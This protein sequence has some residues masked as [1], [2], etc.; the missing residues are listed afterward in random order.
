MSLSCRRSSTGVHVA[1]PPPGRHERRLLGGPAAVPVHRRRPRRR[2]HHLHVHPD[3]E[4]RAGAG[5]RRLPRHLGSRRPPASGHQVHLRRV[6]AGRPASALFWGRGCRRG[7]GPDR[8]RRRRRWRSVWWPR[9][10]RRR[11][12]LPGLENVPINTH[13]IQGWKGTPFFESRAL[14]GW[15]WKVMPLARAFLGWFRKAVP[16]A[17]ALFAL[18]WACPRALGRA[19]FPKIFKNAV[20]PVQLSFEIL[21]LR[22]T[23]TILWG[24]ESSIMISN[25]WTK[26]TNYNWQWLTHTW[27]RI[28]PSSIMVFYFFSFSIINS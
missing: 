8:R 17:R 27:R 24:C 2:P 13:K 14:S 21:A 9:R 25:N 6:E 16:L 28:Q 20:W 7:T 19:L 5:E 4:R 18:K 1:G 22:N 10:P 23:W 15:F 3:A 11:W 12:E 26:S